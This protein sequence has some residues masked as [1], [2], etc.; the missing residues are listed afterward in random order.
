[1]VLT[2]YNHQNRIL[3]SFDQHI[4]YDEEPSRASLLSQGQ[5]GQK[6]NLLAFWDCSLRSWRHRE[7]PCSCCI[8]SYFLAFV[9]QAPVS[10]ESDNETKPRTGKK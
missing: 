7:I 4:S 10:M 6:R 9:A 3:G 5:T 2:S 8:R 1:M